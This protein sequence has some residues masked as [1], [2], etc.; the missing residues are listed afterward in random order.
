[1][2]HVFQALVNESQKNVKNAI[3]QLIGII[4]K[5]ELPTNSWPEVL[6][7]VQQLVTNEDLTNKE[8]SKI[9]ANISFL[10]RIM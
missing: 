2:C 1:M 8:V 9:L 10:S 7:F 3:A 4:V 5:H 6:Q